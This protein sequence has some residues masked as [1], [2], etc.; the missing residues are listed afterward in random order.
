LNQRLFGMARDASRHYKVERVVPE[1]Q[2]EMMG[3][4]LIRFTGE[5]RHRLFEEG[6]D[7]DKCVGKE[8]TTLG[9]LVEGSKDYGVVR[10]E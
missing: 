8:R 7:F 3:E 2:G 10:I 1:V 9:D 5:R 6:C 4:K